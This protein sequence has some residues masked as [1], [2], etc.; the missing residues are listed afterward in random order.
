MIKPHELE[1]QVR[2]DTASMLV[3]AERTIDT[4][5]KRSAKLGGIQQASATLQVNDK[6]PRFV[7]EEIAKRY[8]KNGWSAEIISDQRDGSYLKV[9]YKRETVIH[10]N[11]FTGSY[12]DR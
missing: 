11:H 12:L 1:A 9:E 3:E 4:S 2:E 6:F 7:A 5:L 10:K 8:R